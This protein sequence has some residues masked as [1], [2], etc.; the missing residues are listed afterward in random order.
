MDN[1]KNITVDIGNSRIKSGLFQ[2]D[3]LVETNIWDDLNSLRA[4]CEK[5]EHHK[6]AVSTV[7]MNEA[8]ILT[9]LGEL[10]PRVINLKQEL[11]ISIDYQTPESLGVDR[12]VSAIGASVEYPNQD[13]LIIDLGSCI[14]YDLIDANNTYRGGLISPGLRMR[15]KGMSY[16]TKRLPDISE[17]WT[18]NVID[19]LGKSTRECLNIGS[20]Q[21]IIHE[22][23]GFIDGF[24]SEY[25]S[26]VVI[27]TGGDAPSFESKLKQ[28]IFADQFLVL[29]GLN[30]IL[31]Q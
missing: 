28:P 18:E 12:I 29:K 15:M 3:I 30:R 26:L 16:Y 6:L 7:G 5:T 14:T 10:S 20:Y 31:N 4:Y 23:N 8:E 24:C 2:N 1:N 17:E 21:A 13:I 25:P 9:I 22:L 27:L 11:P 19:S